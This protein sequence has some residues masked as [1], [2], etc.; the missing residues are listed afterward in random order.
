MG[1]EPP[2]TTPSSPTARFFPC[3][4]C[5]AKLQFEPGTTL[6]KCPYCSAENEIEVAEDGASERDFES[7]LARLEGAHATDKIDTVQCNG[8][9]AVLTLA[10]NI[11]SLACP[12]CGTNIVNQGR[13]TSLVMP[14]CVLPFMIR[15]EHAEDAFRKWIKSRWFAPGKLKSRTLLDAALKG[16]YIPAWTYDCDTTTV[17]TGERGDAY[18]VTKTVR[19][20][21]RTTTRQERRIRW[22]PASGTVFVRF[23]DVLVLASNTLPRPLTEKLEPWD[24]KTATPY[25]DDFLAGFTAECYQTDLKQGFG[26]AQVKMAPEIDAAIRADIGGDEQ[27]IHSRRVKYSRITF[28]HILLPVWVSAYRFNGKLYQFLINART[29]EVQGQRPWSAW[30]IAGAVMAGLAVIGVMIWL[31]SR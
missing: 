6:L 24:L 30:K 1:L 8:C 16:I 22:R 18:Y 29:G 7:E 2:P 19:I 26:E 15:R 31:F 4:Q 10:P 17:Y 25:K 12:F 3:K 27:R 11:T 20:N 5:G 21:G 13:A 14:D 28:K 23:D 9:R